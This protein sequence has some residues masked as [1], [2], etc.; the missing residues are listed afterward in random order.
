MTIQDSISQ[1]E[2]DSTIYRTRQ[3][4]PGSREKILDAVAIAAYN[5]NRTYEGCTRCVLAALQEHLQL[6]SP[7]G[8]EAC[9]KASTGLAAG[10]ARMGETCGALTGAIMAL[11]LEF[12][13]ERLALFDAYVETMTLSRRAFG[14]F[15]EMYGTVNCTQI[16][17]QVLGRRY[18]FT[19][20][21]D[22]DAWYA[23]GGLHQC[24]TVCAQAARIAAEIILENR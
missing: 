11:G 21:E 16:Q 24:P 15:K 5:N 14:A 9:L 13:S 12:G 10:V 18:D 8:F 23:D 20:E 19:K 1:L 7:Q 2:K 6:A 17:E 22:R 3:V 4:A